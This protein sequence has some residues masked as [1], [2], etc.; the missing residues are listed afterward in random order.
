MKE[1]V[2]YEQ[3]LP[4]WVYFLRPLDAM[5]ISHYGKLY[6]GNKPPKIYWRFISHRYSELFN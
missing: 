5:T 2:I 1:Y 4:W 6:Y 3:E